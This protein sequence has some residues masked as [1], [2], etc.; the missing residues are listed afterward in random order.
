MLSVK[1]TNRCYK[2]DSCTLPWKCTQ[3]VQSHYGIE[4]CNERVESQ[5]RITIHLCVFRETNKME[6]LTSEKRFQVKSYTKIARPT[7]HT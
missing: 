5:A 2:Y 3:R 4:V 6:K 1:S 7:K